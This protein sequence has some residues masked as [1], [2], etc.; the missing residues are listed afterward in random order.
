MQPYKL[1]LARIGIFALLVFG[2]SRLERL[3]LFVPEPQVLSV[4][5]ETQS[6][7][8]TQYGYV[9]GEVAHNVPAG[10]PGI[11]LYANSEA[12]FY[13]RT[14]VEKSGPVY[15]SLSGI[16]FEVYLTPSKEVA[17]RFPSGESLHYEQTTLSEARYQFP[18]LEVYRGK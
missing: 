11:F 4:Q 1:L 6:A 9:S 18:D 15:D 17:V 12:R 5:D 14:A 2:W 13:P 8:P 16:S 7:R 3:G 10:E